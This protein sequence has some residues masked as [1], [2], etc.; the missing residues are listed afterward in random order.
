MLIRKRVT[1]KRFTNQR[2]VAECV[3]VY[4]FKRCVHA[5]GTT[6]TRTSFLSTSINRSHVSVS[7]CP[8]SCLRVFVVFFPRGGL[9][10]PFRRLSLAHGASHRA[11]VDWQVWCF[12]LSFGR[13]P[14]VLH[15][16]LDRDA[17]F[18]FFL[19]VFGCLAFAHRHQ[20]TETVRFVAPRADDDDG[21]RPSVWEALRLW[22]AETP[23]AAFVLC[24]PPGV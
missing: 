5:L 17:R 8:L 15:G 13:Y 10:P 3:C 22:I 4:M 7:V 9:S 20:K 18:L 1:V 21:V 14:P 6:Y 24:D 23:H 16:V 12:F 11:P 19:C 2:G